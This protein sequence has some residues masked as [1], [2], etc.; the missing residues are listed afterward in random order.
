MDRTIDL[1]SYSSET[2]EIE[3][4]GKIYRGIRFIAGTDRIRQEVH[5]GDLLQTDPKSHRPCDVGRMRRTARVILRD[6]VEQWKAQ[7]ARR[8]MKVTPQANP[9]RRRRAR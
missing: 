7:E 6:L 2:I 8:P 9:Q 1:S 5:F 4:D 3:V